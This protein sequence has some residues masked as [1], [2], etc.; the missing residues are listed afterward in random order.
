MD[1]NF[2][3]PEITPCLSSIEATFPLRLSESETLCLYCQ[4]PL[5]KRSPARRGKFCNLTCFGKNKTKPERFCQDCGGPCDRMR[6]E[7]KLCRTCYH[8]A[9]IKPP[10]TTCRNCNNPLYVPSGAWKRSSRRYGAF[11][12]H[13]CFSVFYRGS[14]NPAFIDGGNRG[15]YPK[16]YRA[17]RRQVL[18]R[19]DN[20]CFLCW[21]DGK[22]DVHHIDRDKHHNEM[23]NL[24]TLCRTCHNR[25]KG[26]LSEVLRLANVLS[27]KLCVTYGYPLRCI[28]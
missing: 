3:L 13:V 17:L 18:E 10:N 14:R 5:P 15:F 24:V 20:H 2:K 12:N 23:S 8:K 27:A 26:T 9:R 11:C 21:A 4:K 22:M 16:A 1:A 19:D 6:V 28:I 25:Q 7:T